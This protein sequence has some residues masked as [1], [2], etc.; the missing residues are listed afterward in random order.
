MKRGNRQSLGKRTVRGAG[1][2]SRVV[3]SIRV[4][5]LATNGRRRSGGV[6]VPYLL[7]ALLTRSS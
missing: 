2:L 5:G 1:S 7:L 3:L 4:V 6:L